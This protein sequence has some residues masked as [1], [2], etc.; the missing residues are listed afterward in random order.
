MQTRPAA[1]SNGHAHAECF[2]RSIKEECLA[3]VVPLGEWHPRRLVRE[4][5][6]HY[7]AEGNRRVGPYPGVMIYAR[8]CRVL[9]AECPPFIPSRLLAAH[10]RT[11][12]PVSALK[13]VGPC[14]R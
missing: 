14:R 12:F 8:P 4:F 13:L 10:D 7:H 6:A 1:S 2:V 3:R 9:G 5:V 11:K